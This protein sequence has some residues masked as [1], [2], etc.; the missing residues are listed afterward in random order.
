MG[1][2]PQDADSDSEYDDEITTFHKQRE[3]VLCNP[4]TYGPSRSA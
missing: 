1:G 3:K 2:Q 4:V